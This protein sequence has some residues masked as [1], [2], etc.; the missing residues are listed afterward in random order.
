MSVERGCR[1][2]VP[3][4]RSSTIG[5]VWE[6]K[7]YEPNAAPLEFELKKI[8]S[9]LDH[10]PRFSKE[11]ME[12]A[13]WMSKYYCYPLGEVFKAMLPASGTTSSVQHYFMTAEG[14]KSWKEKISQQGHILRLLFHRRAAVL[15]PLLKKRVHKLRTEGAIAI[16]TLK[17]LEQ[18][19]LIARE[20]KDKIKLSVADL[21]ETDEPIEGKSCS[22]P[23][24]VLTEKQQEIFQAI[25]SHGFKSEAVSQ[26]FLL[27]GITGAGKT[28]IYLRVLAEVFAMDPNSRAQGLIMVPE[29]SLTPQMTRVFESRFPKCVAVVHSAMTSTERWT[30]LEKVR[31]GSKKILIGPRSAIFAAFQ[32]LRLIVVDEEHDHSYKQT[33]GFN[34]NGRDIAVVRGRLENACVIMGSATPSLESYYNALNGKYTLLTLLERIG[35]SRLPEVEL[36]DSPPL[37]R[38]GI[39][40]DLATDSNEPQEIPIAPRIIDELRKNHQRGQQ[41]MVIVNRRG[42]AC[43]LYS[44]RD[45]KPVSCPQ[46]SISMTVHQ[47]G[48]MLRCHY[49]NAAIPVKRLMER[50]KCNDYVTVGYGS[51]KAED[52]LRQA[53]TGAIVERIDSDSVARK[54]FLAEKLEQFARGEI[55]VLVGTQ[56]L[57]KGHD[58]ANVTLI[59]L[60]EVDQILSLPDFRA[61][62]RVFQLLVQ[63]SG[64]AGR[65]V[66][67]GLVLLQTRRSDHAI[68]AAGIKQNY[69]LFAERELN[70]RSTLGYPPYSRM[71]AVE[72]ECKNQEQLMTFT[73][74]VQDWIIHLM[75]DQPG[76]FRTIRILGPSIPL[77]EK[78]KGHFRRN[79]LFSSPDLSSLRRFVDLFSAFAKPPSGIR[80]KMDIDPQ[81]LL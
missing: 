34:Y 76:F 68:I 78:V 4:G 46:C 63:S 17:K 61:G 36:I 41:S 30:I 21:E 1:V 45:E 40:T 54:G 52:Y 47:K 55:D 20:R 44:L 2:H 56:I 37:A 70:F 43:Y 16:G 71:V 11:N 7:P 75:T 53:L 35:D 27:W 72:I 39:K 24:P 32:S 14:E 26:P 50:E 3:F 31:N 9:V 10:F 66:L 29:I 58:F 62:E 77:A 38:R 69:Q 60:L 18:D 74:S 5:V 42:F 49:C 67:P 28:E 22:R 13:Q 81:S 12:L 51:Q 80:L 6:A 73:Q 23:P 64:R 57:A 59:V 48:K 65:G 8:K 33:S 79:L 15:E 19:G 25:V